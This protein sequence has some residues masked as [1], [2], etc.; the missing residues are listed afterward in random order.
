MLQNVFENLHLACDGG[1]FDPLQEPDSML[2]ITENRKGKGD[3][4]GSGC[5]S[6]QKSERRLS[7]FSVSS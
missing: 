4:Q 1:L 7:S 3:I 5:E 2:C 6:A